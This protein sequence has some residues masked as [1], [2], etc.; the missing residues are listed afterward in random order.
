MFNHLASIPFDQYV[1][2]SFVTATR[3]SHHSKLI[4]ISSKKNPLKFSFMSR[5]IPLWNKLP[6]E[7]INCNSLD[8]FKYKLDNYYY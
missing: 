3:Q 8:Y 7:L 4:P 6:E 1:Q 5:T 2:L